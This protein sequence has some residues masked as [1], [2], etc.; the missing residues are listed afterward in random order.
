M[1]A[2]YKNVLPSFVGCVGMIPVGLLAKKDIYVKNINCIVLHSTKMKEHGV[3][4]K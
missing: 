2:K 4:L 3:L 1:D